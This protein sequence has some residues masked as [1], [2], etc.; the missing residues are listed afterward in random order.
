MLGRNS[1]NLSCQFSKRKSVPPQI[2]QCYDI[3][4]LYFFGSNIIYFRI[5]IHQISHVIFGTKSQFF[6]KRWTLFS[7]MRHN[8]SVFFHQKESIKMQILRLSNARMIINQ[9]PYVTFQVMSQFFFK[10]CITLQCHAHNS[11]EFSFWNII[12]F[13]QKKTVK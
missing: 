3:T 13:G 7:V 9:N 11:Y 2:L 8:S 4:P 6:F 12:C 5:K 10:F 1:P